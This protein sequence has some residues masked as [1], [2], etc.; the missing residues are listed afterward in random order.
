MS[1]VHNLRCPNNIDNEHSFTYG[2]NRL[3]FCEYCGECRELD[4][5]A[6][7]PDP[8]S[9]SPATQLAPLPIPTKGNGIFP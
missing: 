3:I 9:A 8:P 6:G 5:D 1:D 2:E 7:V 4:P